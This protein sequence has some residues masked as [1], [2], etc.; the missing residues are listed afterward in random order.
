MGQKVNKVVNRVSLHVRTFYPTVQMVLDKSLSGIFKIILLVVDASVSCPGSRVV[1]H[2]IVT[3]NLFC[4]G[5]I[6]C[7]RN[8]HF[9]FIVGVECSHN[10]PSFTCRSNFHECFRLSVKL[11]FEVPIATR[12]ERL[13]NGRTEMR[14]GEVE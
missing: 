14:Y 3:S 5:D 6:W 8:K 9:I 12:S 11:Y 4:V 2:R 1:V 10:P 7:Y 13:G